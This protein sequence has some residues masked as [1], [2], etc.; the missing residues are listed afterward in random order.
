[1]KINIH[2]ILNKIVFPCSRGSYLISER[3]ALEGVHAVLCAKE[4][5]NLI[6]NKNLIIDFE[7]HKKFETHNQGKKIVTD[8][9][10]K[11]N[12]D[13]EKE[14]DI[15]IGVADVLVFADD[16]GIFEIGTTR[17]TKILLLLKYISKQT[18]LYTVHFWPYGQKTAII[19]KNWQ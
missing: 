10:K 8:W 13:Y 11:N 4:I 19:F 5:V 9:A 7:K 18:S 2:T 15:S 12:L 3:Q 14:V 6:L 17:P 1:M 16:I